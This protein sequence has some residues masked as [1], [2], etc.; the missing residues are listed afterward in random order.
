MIET[1]LLDNP[2]IDEGVRLYCETS[3]KYQ[4]LEAACKEK[5]EQLQT[6]FLELEDAYNAKWCFLTQAYYH[7]GLGVRQELLTALNPTGRNTA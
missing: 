1:I 2:E 5:Y 6:V 7:M 4:A 3:P